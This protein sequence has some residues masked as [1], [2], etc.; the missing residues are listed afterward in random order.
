MKSDIIV[1]G[2]IRKYMEAYI[3]FWLRSAKSE[4]QMPPVLHITPEANFIS[5]SVLYRP[6]SF[7]F[8]FRRMHIQSWVTLG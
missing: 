7:L 3:Q 2:F 4:E 5:T 6:T 8:K 1:F